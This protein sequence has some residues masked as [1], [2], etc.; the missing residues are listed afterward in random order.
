MPVSQNYLTTVKL[1][2]K[3]QQKRIAKTLEQLGEEDLH[4]IF[5]VDGNSI[6]ILIQHLHGNMLSRFRDFLTTDGEK[7]DRHRDAEFEE[8]HYS[9][10]KLIGLLDEGYKLVENTLE[11]LNAGDLEKTVTI[12]NQPQQV[13]EAIN[14]QVAHYEYHIGQIVLMARMIRG[15]S[16]QTLTI[17]KGGSEAYNEAMKNIY[18][19]ALQ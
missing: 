6:A 18:K 7:P 1:Q 8:K 15:K 14:R 11:S 16:W 2:F 17:P 9:K 12:R 19:K 5:G 3:E 13:V 4:R 10:E